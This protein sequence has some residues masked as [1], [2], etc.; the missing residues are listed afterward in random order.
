MGTQS[1][2]RAHP[3]PPLPWS[4]ERLQRRPQAQLP[5]PPTPHLIPGRR[6]K[7]LEDLG[8]RAEDGG[9]AGTDVGGQALQGGGTPGAG[10]A[11]AA[12]RPRSNGALLAWASLHGPASARTLSNAA[13]SSVPAPSRACPPWPPRSSRR[14]RCRRTGTSPP[15]T[16]AWVWVCAWGVGPRGSAAA[17]QAPALVAGTAIPGSYTVHPGSKG[18]SQRR[19]R[20]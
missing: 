19:R 10:A 20:Q 5:S 18:G 16:C 13:P 14:W 17:R 12:L 2:R 11:F 4:R 6:L 1:V 3:W 7:A 15:R 8:H 9:L